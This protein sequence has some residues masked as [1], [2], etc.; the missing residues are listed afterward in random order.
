VPGVIGA[1]VTILEEIQNSA[2]DSK[3]DLATLLRKCKVLAAR[4]GSQP[5]EDWLVWESNGYPRDAPV[6]DYRIW[7]LEVFGHFS[8][9]FGSA[10]RNA[11][12]PIALLKFISE[13]A[14]QSYVRYQSR[15][16]IAAI[17]AILS[18]TT[19]GKVAVSTGDLAVVIGMDLYQGHNCVQT[20]AE[21]S[22]QHLVEL[23]NSVRNR[24]LD[25]ALALWKEAPNAG[26]AQKDSTSPSPEVNRVTQIFNTTVYGGAANLVGTA[27]ESS[28]S[29]NIGTKDFSSLET[30]L[31]ANLV[32]PADIAE[33]KTALESDPPPTAPE[34]FG[35]KVSAWMGRM[36]EKA[37]AGGWGIGIGAAGNLL[38]QAIA[39]YYGIGG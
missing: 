15:D 17:E 5:L 21:F 24:I 28:I 1:V 11:R 19:K 18:K 2:V 37:A 12:I 27:S 3:S 9:P 23:L 7:S 29:F 30:F 33:L 20:W 6:P 31:I 10:I 34:N 36:I 4:L 22:T 38:S 16:S 26:E 35:P 25:F 8:G 39:K 32:S 14:K 13:E